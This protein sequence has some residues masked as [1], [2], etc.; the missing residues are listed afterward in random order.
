[1][2]ESILTMVADEEAEVGKSFIFMGE[3]IE[4]TDCKFS[5]ICLN[6]EKG[7]KY[8]ITTV[9]PLVHEC[10]LT[11]GSARVVEVIKTE[12]V[13]CVDKKYAIDGSL[14]TFFPSECKH[15]GCDHYHQCNPEGLPREEKVKVGIVGERANCL[16]GRVKNV[17][18]IQ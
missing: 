1:M 16:I 15:V 10:I 18:T 5:K 12:R 7:R 2:P 13:V 17:V 8:I 3:Q 14:I 11:E 9:R 4:C 6:L